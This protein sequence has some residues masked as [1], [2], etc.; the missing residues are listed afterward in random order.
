MRRH[1]IS[2]VY[3]FYL[4][5]PEIGH[6][7]SDEP[8]PFHDFI[9]ANKGCN[10]RIRRYLDKGDANSTG[11]LG[12]HARRCWKPNIVEAALEAD[13]LKEARKVIAGV[14]DGTITAH[15]ERTGQGKQTYSN[16]QL[17]KAET[18]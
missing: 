2:P 10:K 13:G 15:F 17:T 7:E 5:E 16:V 1:W 11:N 6:D 14:R 8:R 9:C 4:P 12:K 3:A 18:R